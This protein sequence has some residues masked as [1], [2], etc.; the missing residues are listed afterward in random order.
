[1]PLAT[2]FLVVAVI[3]F[4]ISAWSRWWATPQPYYPSLISGGLF[5]W[6]LS[7]LWPMIVK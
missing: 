1:M 6:A 2:V 5:F 4:A 3:L 7:Q